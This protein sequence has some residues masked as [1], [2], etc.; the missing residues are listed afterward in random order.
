MRAT[1]DAGPFAAAHLS[2][3]VEPWMGGGPKVVRLRHCGRR[4]RED[5]ALPVRARQALRLSTPLPMVRRLRG[6]GLAA[7]ATL[8]GCPWGIGMQI[9]FRAA[10]G[11]HIGLVLHSGRIIVMAAGCSWLASPWLF[12]GEARKIN[13]NLA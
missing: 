11:G 8:C 10:T 6:G 5:D 13:I 9:V 1:R 7:S 12:L 3:E 4:V 2:E